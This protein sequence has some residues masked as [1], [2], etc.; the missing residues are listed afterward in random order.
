MAQND[1]Q[2]KVGRIMRVRGLTRHMKNR[3]AEHGYEV[4][5]IMEKPSGLV[6]T[7]HTRDGYLG[8]RMPGEDFEEI[9]G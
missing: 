9:T 4:E 8:W 1:A 3:I 5:I 6:L 7:K 2:G